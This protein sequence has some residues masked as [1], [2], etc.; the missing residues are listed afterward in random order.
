M[1]ATSVSNAPMSVPSMAD[2]IVATTAPAG[3]AHGGAITNNN[4]ATINLKHGTLSG[5]NAQAGNTGV[6]QGGANKPPRDAAEAVGTLPL[7]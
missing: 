6:N 1:H 4:A 7:S 3:F 5:N 2:S